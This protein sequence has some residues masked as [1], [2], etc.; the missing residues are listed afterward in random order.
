MNAAI[1]RRLLWV[2]GL[3]AFA[4]G[5]VSLVLPAYLLALGLSPFDVGVIATATLL[6]SAALSLAVGMHAHRL[7]YRSLLLGAAV[8]MAATGFSFAAFTDFWPL[9]VVITWAPPVN[10]PGK[11]C[12]QPGSS[13]SRR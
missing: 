9:V 11:V 13:S 10:G 12:T 7:G 8:L 1:V 2:R 3:R 4:D 5:Y 6:G